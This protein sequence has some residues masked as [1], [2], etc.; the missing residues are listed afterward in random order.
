MTGTTRIRWEGTG[1]GGITGH[2]GTH[3]P[4][5]FQIFPPPL[6]VERWALM[7]QIPGMDNRRSRSD[8]PDELK[9]EAE[10]WLVEFIS[11]L[12]A[13]FEV[14]GHYH[15]ATGHEDTLCHCPSPATYA[16]RWPNKTGEA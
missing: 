13:S 16:P 7:A 9:A 11:S 4:W 12:G 14:P 5:M 3:Q 6:T 2:V 10:A 15:S 8:S 1:L